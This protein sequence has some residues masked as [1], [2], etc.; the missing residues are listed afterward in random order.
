LAWGF[1]SPNDRILDIQV[2]G[3]KINKIQFVGPDKLLF[4]VDGKITISSLS[5]N[6]KLT[7]KKVLDDF[8]E[9]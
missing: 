2:N 8:P 5:T 6:K 9:S 1:A 3:K 7:F 4:D